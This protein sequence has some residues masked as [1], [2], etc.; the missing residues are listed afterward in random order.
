[1]RENELA[2]PFMSKAKEKL[3][4]LYLKLT[5]TQEDFDP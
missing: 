1:M 5:G 3:G 2:T 4:L